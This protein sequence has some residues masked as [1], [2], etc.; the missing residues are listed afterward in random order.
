MFDFMYRVLYFCPIH[1][2]SVKLKF[3]FLP[4]LMSRLHFYQ[5][6]FKSICPTVHHSDKETNPTLQ[7]VFAEW[8]ILAAAYGKTDSV[9]VK[10]LRKFSSV[11]SKA[12]SSF[13]VSDA[14][15]E[16]GYLHCLWF[17]ITVF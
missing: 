14:R 2:E 6:M 9:L 7:S 8:P 11:Q 10:S 15:S 16:L 12:I 17:P 4:L 3:K 5:D 13:P 1:I